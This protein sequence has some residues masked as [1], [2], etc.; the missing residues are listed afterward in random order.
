MREIEELKKTRSAFQTAIEAIDKIIEL[1]EREKQ[2]EDITE[3]TYTA[4]GK[5]T[6]A[7]L[8]LKDFSE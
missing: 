5:M 4:I 6:S 2:G 1:D 3:E 8:A 7:M